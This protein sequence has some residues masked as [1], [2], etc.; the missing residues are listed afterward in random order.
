MVEKPAP[1]ILQNLNDGASEKDLDAAEKV[2]DMPMPQEW[3]DL[4]KTH[5]GMNDHQ[6]F[7]S[8]FYDM[9][10]LPLTE[11]LKTMK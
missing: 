11:V 3:R 9:I 10:F 6:N 8:L 2:L 4:Y 5:N 7:G 1:K